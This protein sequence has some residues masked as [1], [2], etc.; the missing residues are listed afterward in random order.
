MI[1]LERIVHVQLRKNVEQPVTQ[2]S[3]CGIHEHNT[4]VV[5]KDTNACNIVSL[6]LSLHAHV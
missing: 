5:P 6:A 1:L 3:D 2:L 4:C